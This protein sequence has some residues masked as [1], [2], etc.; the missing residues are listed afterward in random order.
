MACDGSTR[1]RKTAKVW[2]VRDD[3][4]AT[5]SSDALG[6]EATNPRMMAFG[7]TIVTN[8]IVQ[9]KL[10][11]VALLTTAGHGDV[12]DIARQSRRVLYDLAAPPPAQV[13]RGLRFEIDAR[14]RPDGAGGG[15]L[16]RHGAMGVQVEPESVGADP[17]PACYGRGGVRPTLTDAAVVLGY[18]RPSAH[19]E[20]SVRMETW[21][22]GP[23]RISPACWTRPCRV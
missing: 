20:G 6:P 21:R 1:T 23:S 2:S 17:G 7:T 22:N 10:G 3:P 11:R 13:P 4:G 19:V 8:A 16:V 9:G 14:M 12:L 5:V 15:S 18:L